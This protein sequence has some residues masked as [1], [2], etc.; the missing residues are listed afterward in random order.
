[1]GTFNF[2]KLHNKLYIKARL[3]QDVFFHKFLMKNWLVG[4]VEQSNKE[5][6]KSLNSI[7]RQRNVVF[8]N[9]N[10]MLNF[11]LPNLNKDQRNI[12]FSNSHLYCPLYTQRCSVSHQGDHE[13]N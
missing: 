7:F 12:F 1:M 4:I 9:A 11:V 6:I 3:K 10:L 2:N 5:P 8:A 13:Y